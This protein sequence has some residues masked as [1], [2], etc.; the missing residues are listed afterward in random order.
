MILITGATGTNGVEIIRQLS[1][2]GAKVRALV[3]NPDKA[4]T[5]FAPGV[6]VAKGDFNDPASLARATAGVEKVF[7]VSPSDRMQVAMEANVVDAAKIAGV[8]HLVKL[9]VVLAAA[10]APA[11]LLRWHFQSEEHIR[12]SGVPFTILRPNMFMQEVWRQSGSIKSHGVFYLPLGDAKISLVDVRDI[13]AC[14]VSALT[15]PG[16]EGK[17]YD[18]TGPEALSFHEVAQTLSA[19]AG[20]RVNYMPITMAAF[21]GAFV[22]SGAPAWLADLVCELYGTFPGRNDL[23]AG[24]VFAATG[25]EARDF[26]EF[27]WDHVGAWRGG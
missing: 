22:G 3:R 14:A 11:E 9:S 1:A 12:R 10:D 16:H 23:V 13:A 26:E 25:E 17:T 4:A 2:T 7:L 21:R 24:G 15:Q 20:H 5:L 8:K 18:I 27:A 19:V 6:E